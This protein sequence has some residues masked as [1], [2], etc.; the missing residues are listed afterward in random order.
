VSGLSD[1]MEAED[2]EIIFDL[3]KTLL[4][5]IFLRVQKFF[6]LLLVCPLSISAKRSPA[7]S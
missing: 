6:A 4:N 1:I 2:V 7:H 5:K 3:K